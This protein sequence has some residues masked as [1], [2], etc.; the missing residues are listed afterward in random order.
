MDIVV[1]H[2]DGTRQSYV[3]ETNA[4]G[5]ITT[6]FSG[7][8]DPANST[9]VTDGTKSVSTYNPV[10]L[11]LTN[12]TYDIASAAQET[13]LTLSREVYAYD[14]PGCPPRCPNR[15]ERPSHWPGW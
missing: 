13:P 4:T 10:G 3:Y 11:L 9:N 8:A 14:R 7:A 5:R 12:A 1:D 6:V 15:R 2:P